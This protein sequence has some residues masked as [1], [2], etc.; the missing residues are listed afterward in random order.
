VIRTINLFTKAVPDTPTSWLDKFSSVWL[1]QAI[2]YGS[3]DGVSGNGT[4]KAIR[5]YERVHGLPEDGKIGQQLAA[6]LNAEYACETEDFELRL[7]SRPGRERR[8]SA[9]EV[10]CIETGQHFSSSFAPAGTYSYIYSI[11]PRVPAGRLSPSRYQ[12]QRNSMKSTHYSIFLKG[13]LL[14]LPLSNDG[15]G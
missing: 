12:R 13:V 2:N 7:R 6:L 4:R 14:I 3:I 11:P 8:R 15:S 1:A 5:E 10:A 9:Q